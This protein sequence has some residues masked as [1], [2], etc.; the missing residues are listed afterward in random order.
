M[1]QGTPYDFKHVSGASSVSSSPSDSSSSPT[2]SYSSD[3]FASSTSSEKSDTSATFASSIHSEKSI[4][5]SDKSEPIPIPIPSIKRK[6]VAGCR[7]PTNTGIEAFLASRRMGLGSG[8]GDGKS[9][10]VTPESLGVMA[11][12][13]GQGGV[14]VTQLA[15]QRETNAPT[16]ADDNSASEVSVTADADTCDVNNL[17]NAGHDSDLIE[18]QSSAGKAESENDDDD[19]N[20]SAN[21]Y[22]NEEEYEEYEEDDSEDDDGTDDEHNG[23]L[24]LLEEDESEVVTATAVSMK[25]FGST[26]LLS[27]SKSDSE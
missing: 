21:E 10:N 24:L 17:G 22:D 11:G 8:N 18:P 3:T 1:F 9:R 20:R 27:E 13:E 12:H 4:T 19:E 26:D 14:S 7:I 25:R 16:S 23:I 5:T 6:D 15:E 2:S